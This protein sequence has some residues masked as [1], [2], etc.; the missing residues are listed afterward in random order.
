M[1]E[2][3]DGYS[4]GLRRDGVQEGAV[5]V[6]YPVGDVLL[7]A[8]ARQ[9]GHNHVVDTPR[10]QG[11]RSHPK[12]GGSSRGRPIQYNDVGR[13]VR[14]HA[15]A[16]QGFCHIHPGLT[17]PSLDVAGKLTTRARPRKHSLTIS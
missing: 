12:M 9:E 4:L 14:A 6:I 10:L 15:G 17:D 8:V 13:T 7:V 2:E 11:L 5:D 16:D 3:E 1:G